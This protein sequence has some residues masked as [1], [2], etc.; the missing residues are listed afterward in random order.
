MIHALPNIVETELTLQQRR[1]L[2]QFGLLILVVTLILRVAL[3]G[4]MFARQGNRSYV[5]ITSIVF[6]ILLYSLFQV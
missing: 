4:Y 2:I 1:S 6:V 3:S 5:V